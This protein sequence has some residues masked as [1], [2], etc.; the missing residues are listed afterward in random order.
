MDGGVPRQA[1]ERMIMTWDLYST[2]EGLVH[3]TFV[4]SVIH[5]ASLLSKLIPVYCKGGW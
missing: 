4:N 1:I 3:F 5:K 2:S